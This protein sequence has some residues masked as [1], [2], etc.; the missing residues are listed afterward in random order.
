M[1]FDGQIRRLGRFLVKSWDGGGSMVLIGEDDSYQGWM[2][3]F[4]FG[5][6]LIKIG[7]CLS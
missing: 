3:L 4:N 7:I 6:R 1:C 2:W 5:S